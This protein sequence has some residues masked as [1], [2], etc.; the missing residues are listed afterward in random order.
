MNSEDLGSTLQI[1]KTKFHLTI[2]TARSQQGRIKGIRSVCGHQNL[3][4]SS[5][6]ETVHLVDDFKHSSLDFIV[7]TRSII[8]SSATDSINFVKKDNACSLG[9][10]HLEQFSDHPGSFSNILLHQLRTN[11]SDKAGIG[12]ISNGSGGQSFTRSGGTVQQNSLGRVDT[13]GDESFG[14]QQRHF[15]DFTKTI[16]LISTASNIG[17]GD[18]GLFFN[19]HHSD[20]GVNF[21]WQGQMNLIF[22][23]VNSHSHAFFD[24]SGRY[25]FCKTD[26]KLGNLSDVD[27][28][29]Q[30]ITSIGFND[31][32]TSSNLQG[33]IF[34]HQFLITGEIPLRGQTQTGI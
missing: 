28:I 16:Q 6:F 17:I 4:I 3:N 27:H 24:I 12:T 20:T 26:H 22:C 23:S 32:G 21:W 25:F 8:E 5:R 9:L 33:L 11:N 31:F 1:R 10:G 2:Q 34:T 19:C 13:Q 15:Y 29:F 30:I 18:I 14:I 7:T